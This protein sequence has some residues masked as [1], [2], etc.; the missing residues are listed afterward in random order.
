MFKGFSQATV[1]FMWGIRLNNDKAWFEAHKEDYKEHFQNPMKELAREAYELLSAESKERSFVHKVSRIYKDARRVR[2]GG[3]YRDHLWFSI[4]RPSGDWVSTPVFWFELNPD[5]W[6]Y[7]L[8]Y[9]AAKAET[10]TRFRERI[11]DAPDRFEDFIRPL[12]AQ[13]EFVLDGPEY[14]RKKPAPTPASAPW[15]NKKSLSLIHTQKS[16][17]EIF[18]RGLLDRVAAGFRFL[19]PYYDYFTA[20]E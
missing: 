10:M 7:G 4:E 5:T 11:D 19:M 14:A 6:S 16:G 2:G 17:D 12:E 1:D 13:S 18:S 9:Y 8:G 20:L 15:Y 3:M